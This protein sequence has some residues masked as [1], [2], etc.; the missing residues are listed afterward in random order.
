MSDHMLTAL[1]MGAKTVTRR[2]NDGPP[3]HREGDQLYV[4]EAWRP[5]ES[6]GERFVKYR[7]GGEIEAW[8]RRLNGEWDRIHDPARASAW[9]P[10]R[11]MFRA[12]ARYWL[13]VEGAHIER[14]QDITGSDA[15]RE[16]TWVATRSRAPLSD[17][18]AR[19][20]FAQTWNTI[21][22][23]WTWDDNPCVEVIR[24]RLLDADELC[25]ACGE[26]RSGA[27]CARCDA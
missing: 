25:N 17:G 11:F 3:R 20:I 24:F 19:F 9:R 10:A 5:I 4:R 1:A 8:P 27:Y 23:E 7:A 18:E 16:G 22:P 26:P 21:H 15:R 13:E 14:L 2:L 6:E 12:L